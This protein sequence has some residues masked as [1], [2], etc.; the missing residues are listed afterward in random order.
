[1]KPGDYVP[2]SWARVNGHQT[3]QWLSDGT[4]VL[5]ADVDPAALERA[6]AA[7]AAGG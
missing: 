4:V 6:D 5:V 7:A 3:S 1:M 2:P